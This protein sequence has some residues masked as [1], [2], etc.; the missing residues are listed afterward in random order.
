MIDITK[1]E[2]ED[3][4][5]DT[6]RGLIWKFNDLSRQLESVLEAKKEGKMKLN[7]VDIGEQN[8][9]IIINL[10][11]IKL[12]YLYHIIGKNWDILKEERVNLKAKLCEN[13]TL[14]EICCEKHFLTWTKLVLLEEYG[15]K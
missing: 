13:F 9:D 7:S 11:K 14:Q 3:S 6:K 15:F 12:H 10:I 5:L 2:F 8:I 1:E 4:Q